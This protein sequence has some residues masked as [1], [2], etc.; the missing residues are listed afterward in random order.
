MLLHTGRGD[1][2]RA[3]FLT[4]GE[5]GLPDTPPADA[6]RIRE[7]ESEAAAAVLGL[8]SIEFLRLPDGRCGEAVAEAGKRLR[9]L[10]ERFAPDHILLP[11]PDDGHPDHVACL[12]IV[13]AALGGRGSPPHLRGYEVWT[14][15]EAIHYVED[16]TGVM[17]RKLEAIGRHASQMA[18]LRYD[19]AAAGLSQYRG[20]LM[21]AC[22]Y[23]EVQCWLS[24][25][26]G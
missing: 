14:P 8:G 15:M 25:A 23:A 17:Q 2:V 24:P 4:S 21:G 10:I 16:I 19:L 3:V 12:P 7:R 26:A 9:G 18:Q 6:Q 20:A 1:E 11:H 5:A 13:R 22:P